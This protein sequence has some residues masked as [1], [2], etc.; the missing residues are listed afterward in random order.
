MDA[1]V[2]Q[3]ADWPLQCADGS[4]WLLVDA[5]LVE[6]DRILSSL[7]VWGCHTYPVFARSRLAAF[8]DKGPHLVSLPREADAL[9][10]RLTQLLQAHAAA[11]AFSWLYS[12]R[13]AD[14]I[15]A[16]LSLLGLVRVD[17]DLEL[18]CRFADTRVLTALW[19]ALTE[20]QRSWL[21]PCISAWGCPD[22]A[23]GVLDL[24]V[25]SAMPGQ[26]AT[27]PPEILELDAMQFSAVLDASEPDTVFNALK[28]ST[29]EFVRDGVRRSDLHQQIAQALGRATALHVTQTPDRL[30]FVVLS[31]QC[32]ELFFQQSALAQTWAEVAQGARLETLMK[33]WPAEIWEALAPGETDAGA[34]GILEGDWQ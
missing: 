31:L 10:S 33:L 22:R 25:K 19:A 13:P 12:V 24:R 16:A 32:G 20:Q 21:A 30:Q 4:P 17:G 3:V 15:C 14:E 23:G 34:L 29:P 27:P 7:K 2:S 28:E 26:P 1:A 18:H 11:P 8:G 6:F 9:R 5:A